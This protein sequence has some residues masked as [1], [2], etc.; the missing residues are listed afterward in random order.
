[1]SIT[2]LHSGLEINLLAPDP[3]MISIR[4]IAVQL[5]RISRFN[6]ATALP[7]Y[8]AQHS[9]L[10][11]QIA[12]ILGASPR[13]QFVAL[14]HD[15]HEAF[16]GDITRPV[17]RALAE[18]GDIQFPDLR[19][20]MDKAIFWAFGMRFDGLPDIVKTADEVALSTEWRDLMP[21]PCPSSF[22]PAPM[23]VKPKRH[24]M[25]ELEFLKTFERLRIATGLQLGCDDQG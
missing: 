11:A 13:D 7:Y 8:V 3:A 21:G 20:R 16:L 2:R 10:V 23:P 24:D 17:L 22:K 12:G 4:D 5:S 15:A 1:M 18:M 25:A 9:V 6:G 19:W 14:L